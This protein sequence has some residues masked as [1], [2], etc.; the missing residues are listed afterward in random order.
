MAGKP[1]L[2]LPFDHDHPDNARR[3]V[4]AGVA[5]IVDPWKTDAKGL[6]KAIRTAP[7]DE[8]IGKGAERL[9][10]ELARFDGPAA[11][12][13]FIERLADEGRSCSTN[14]PLVVDGEMIA[15]TGRHGLG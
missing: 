15:G 8:V 6:A 1:A 4:G 11:C 14:A 13:W 9:S 5:H 7:G 12:A 2:V 3:L 10:S